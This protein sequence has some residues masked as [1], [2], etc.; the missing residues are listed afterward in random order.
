[1]AVEAANHTVQS[2]RVISVKQENDALTI[3][4]DWISNTEYFLKI[5][6]LVDEDFLFREYKLTKESQVAGSLL[7]QEVSQKNPFYL[8]QD[9]QKEIY[10]FKGTDSSSQFD[11]SV[12]TQR[13]QLVTLAKCL[14]LA[15]EKAI[16][17]HYFMHQG[18]L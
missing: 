9:A 10:A 7:T 3:D 15:F 14:L 13:V 16:N 4:I 1:M 8:L 17:V 6:K 5:M 18:K 11:F 2:I 12:G